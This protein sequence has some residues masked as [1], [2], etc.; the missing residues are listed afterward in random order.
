MFNK[1]KNEI[2]RNFNKP[3]NRI[4]DYFSLVEYCGHWGL[5]KFNYYKMITYLTLV[6]LL[7]IEIGRSIYFQYRSLDS[8]PAIAVRRAGVQDNSEFFLQ[9]TE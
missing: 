6:M 7:P 5:I 8:P 3:M 4:I 1:I 2:G 9:I